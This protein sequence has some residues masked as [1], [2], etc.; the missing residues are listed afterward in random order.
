MLQYGRFSST[1]KICAQYSKYLRYTRLKE[2]SPW[3]RVVF[4]LFPLL[5]APSYVVIFA[6]WIKSENN[7]RSERAAGAGEERQVIKCP[8][9]SAARPTVGDRGVVCWGGGGVCW[10]W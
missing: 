3:Q 10:E 5:Q 2:M 1:N 7:G 4:L 9:V 8:L 6:E